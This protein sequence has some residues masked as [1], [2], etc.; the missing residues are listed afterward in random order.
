METGESVTV[1]GHPGLGDTTL[2]YTM[3]TGIVSNPRQVVGG[4][5]YLQ[6]NAS[7]N[8]GSSGSPVLSAK[9]ELIG[10]VVLKG[11]IEG[12]GFAVP[13]NRL[14]AFLRSCTKGQPATATAPAR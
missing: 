12:T 5:S 6:T 10:L 14:E 2:N 8:P 1:I 11:G 9:G 3:T 13:A 4:V 7:V